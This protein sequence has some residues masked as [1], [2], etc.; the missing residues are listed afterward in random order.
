MTTSE[1][2]VIISKLETNLGTG[3]VT[4]SFEGRSVTYRSAAEIESAIRYFK[5]ELA[6]AQGTPTVKH[7]RL[8]NGMGY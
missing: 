8:F 2:E 6:D 3:T 7:V 5:N 1:I 4:V